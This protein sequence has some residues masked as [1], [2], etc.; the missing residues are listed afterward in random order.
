MNDQAKSYKTNGD[1]GNSIEDT[2]VTEWDMVVMSVVHR[3]I[4]IVQHAQKK[5]NV[6]FITH[7]SHSALCKKHILVKC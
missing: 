6:K 3:C 2:Q 5:I 4:S 1:I 7:L